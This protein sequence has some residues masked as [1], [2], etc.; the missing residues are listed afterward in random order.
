MCQCANMVNVPI[1]PAA[2]VMTAVANWHHWH[3]GTLFNDQI[4]FLWI[5]IFM[6]WR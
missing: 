4:I 2:Y 1:F 6:N 3:I 5:N